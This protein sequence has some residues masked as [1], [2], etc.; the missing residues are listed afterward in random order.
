MTAP[1]ATDRDARRQG[2]GGGA[3]TSGDGR[4]DPRPI[5]K[6]MAPTSRLAFLQPQ[7]PAGIRGGS[8]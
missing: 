5:S 8:P 7:L 2:K 3:E 4:R 1:N 6:N